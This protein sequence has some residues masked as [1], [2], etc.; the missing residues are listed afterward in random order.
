[1]A[2]YDV[3]LAFSNVTGLQVLFDNSCILAQPYG[4]LLG[5]GWADVFIYWPTCHHSTA[6]L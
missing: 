5:G 2:A 4:V 3:M 6:L 1:V